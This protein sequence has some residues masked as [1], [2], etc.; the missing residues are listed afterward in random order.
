MQNDWCRT[1]GCTAELALLEAIDGLKLTMRCQG[2]GHTF[3]DDFETIYDEMV[4]N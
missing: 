2:C 4:E 1:P 3:V